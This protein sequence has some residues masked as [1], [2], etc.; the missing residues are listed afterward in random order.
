[1]ILDK[2]QR[3]LTALR[4]QIQRLDR[5][6]IQLQRE[7]DQL[8]RWRLAIFA[9]L[10]VVSAVVLLTLGALVWAA[11]T[12]ALLIPFLLTVGRHRQVEK[13]IARH[14]LWQ[15]LK[16]AQYA[17]M[18][19][20][21]DNIPPAQNLRIMSEHLFAH[22]LDLIG[23]RSLFRLIDVSITLEGGQRLCDWLLEM[24]LELE[25]TAR[26]QAAVRELMQMP[27]LRYQMIMN[28]ALASEEYGQ[29]RGFSPQRRSEQRQ[30]KSKWSGTRLL[31]WLDSQT[32][33]K[34]LRNV[35][36]LLLLLVPVNFALLAGYLNG[37]LPPL[38]VA[39]WFVYAAITVSQSRKVDPSF[40]D[41]AFLSD[42]LKQLAAVFGILESRP[43]ENKPALRELCAPLRHEK[44]RPSKQLRRVN[45][46]LV[47]AGL[48]I[49]PVIGILLNAL[50][51]W[52][53]FFAYRLEVLKQELADLLPRWLDLWF[54]LEAL[55]GLANFGYL[56]PEAT[57]AE[58][59]PLPN[60]TSAL[61][62]SGK[63]A[64]GVAIPFEAHDIR[65]PLIKAEE[66]IG[67]DYV[68]SQLGTVTI[69]TGSN[70]A[71]KSSFLRTIG[72]N[73]RLALAG[74]PALASSLRFVP[75]RVAA[76]ITVTDSVTDGFSFFYAEVRR[77]KALLDELQRPHPYPL[78][79]LIDEIFRGTN[80]RERLIGSR[81]FVQ[82]LTGCYGTGAIA[83]HDLELVKLA[84]ANPNINNTHF[85]DDV[86][87]ERMVFDYKLHPGPCPT[88]NAL[89]IM[90]LA[91]L[92]IALEGQEETI[93]P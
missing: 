5:C 23:E 21:W 49:N 93:V 58:I 72:V 65:H 45:R 51:P 55:N 54:E 88:T 34:S 91:G 24:D 89:R 56:Y 52:D 71:G 31:E 68:V 14:F 83:T 33:I 28:A 85:R 1:M 92:P 19:L 41:A 79:F 81:S 32:E 6:V 66:R 50:A 82:A 8:T 75:F 17:R 57:F 12:V 86:I 61:G 84:E 44:T 4:N 29:E 48:R 67:N 80:N 27:A 13:S 63:F 62:A 18:V 47:A 42:S 10:L 74:A 53:V 15:R 9:L 36:I 64:D 26:R 35:L 39:S 20:D 2:R 3:R 73:V 38:W 87:G 30:I 59:I 60:G 78:F 25:R 69:I 37:W 16:K 90:V 46:L 76:S 40:R 7:S 22:D 43:L 70:M 77:L 11:I